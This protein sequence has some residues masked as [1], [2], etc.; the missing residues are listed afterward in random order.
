MIAS[1]HDNGLRIDKD[2]IDLSPFVSRGVGEGTVITDMAVPFVGTPKL[3]DTKF[4]EKTKKEKNKDKEDKEEKM[5]H[6]CH[7]S[8]LLHDICFTRTY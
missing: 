7:L 5:K 2:V 8:W 1:K 6:L 4:L 3:S